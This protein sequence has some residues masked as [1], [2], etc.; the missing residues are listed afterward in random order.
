MAFSIG[1]R[2]QVAEARQGHMGNAHDVATFGRVFEG[3]HTLL[4]GC[5]VVGAKPCGGAWEGNASLCHKPTY[6]IRAHVSDV[7]LVN[8][9][10]LATSRQGDTKKNVLSGELLGSCNQR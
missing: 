3:L 9:F 8:L 6:M 7:D 5:T 1:G 2:A 10:R 4:M